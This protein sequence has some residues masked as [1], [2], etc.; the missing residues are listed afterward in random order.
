MLVANVYTGK[1]KFLGGFSELQ[2]FL[3]DNFSNTKSGHEA[4]KS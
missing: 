1:T 2:S 3:I 4:L